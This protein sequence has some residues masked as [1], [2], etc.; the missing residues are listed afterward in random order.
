MWVCLVYC[1]KTN[2]NKIKL[3][4]RA[5]KS[6]FV[7]YASNSKAYRLL[8]LESNVIL[9]SIEVEFFKNC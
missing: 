3:G 1:K 4:P 9:E 6:A 7:G 5:T 8:N 2:P